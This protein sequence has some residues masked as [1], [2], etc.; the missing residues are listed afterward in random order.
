MKNTD[1]KNVFFGNNN[2]S[3]VYYGT[4]LLWKKVTTPLITNSLS[5]KYPNNSTESEWVCRVNK[6]YHALY[7]DDNF[8]FS[9]DFEDTITDL[10]NLFYNNSVEKIYSLPDTSKVTTMEKMFYGCK[11]LNTINLNIK[12]S[13]VNS[14][15]YMFDGCANLKTLNLTSFE[16]PLLRN[17][18][19]MFRGCSELETINFNTFN[20]SNLFYNMDGMFSNCKKLHTVTGEILKIKQDLSLKYSPLTNDSAMVFINGLDNVTSTRTLQLST[21]T[22]STLSEE[23]IAMATA[24]GWTVTNG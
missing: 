3:A 16:T 10:S 19:S 22:Y 6:E 17:V 7:C 8:E 20:L 14:M 23:Q 13:K 21:S 18:N 4:S 9:E 1:I 15:G 5:G 12:T 11:N 24:K 2:A